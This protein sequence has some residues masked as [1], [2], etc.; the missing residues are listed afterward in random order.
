MVGGVCGVVDSGAMIA[1]QRHQR[2]GRCDVAILARRRQL[3]RMGW[4]RLI[5]SS[6]EVMAGTASSFAFVIIIILISY[7]SFSSL[8]RN[9]I[10]KIYNPSPSDAYLTCQ[11]TKFPVRFHDQTMGGVASV[12]NVPCSIITKLKNPGGPCV[13]SYLTGKCYYVD[14]EE[15]LELY[16]NLTALNRNGRPKEYNYAQCAQYKRHISRINNRVEMLLRYEIE[17]GQVQLSDSEVRPNQGQARAPT[18]V[19][20]RSAAPAVEP[21]LNRQVGEQ[22]TPAPAVTPGRNIPTP[23]GQTTDKVDRLA[24]HVDRLVLE[25][26]QIGDLAGKTSAQLGDLAGK[27][28]AQIGELAGKTSAQIG[29]VAEKTSAQIGDLAEVVKPVA[30]QVG[31]N[32]ADIAVLQASHAEFKAETKKS[33]AELTKRLENVDGLEKQ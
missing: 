11:R 21:Q 16:A 3:S 6:A 14:R 13:T 29:E 32:T 28:S 27:T 20:T 33:I 18:D 19:D 7:F 2:L 1:G 25:C 15:E 22:Y 30:H 10:M 9:T 17:S 23:S 26:A 12:A 24:L 8:H 4:R 31:R 5:R